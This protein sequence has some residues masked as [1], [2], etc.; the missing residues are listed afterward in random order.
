MP[1]PHTE[2]LPTM[3]RTKA[4]RAVAGS[5]WRFVGGTLT[6]AVPV[7]SMADGAAVLATVLAAAGGGADGHV[8]VEL[9]GGA[10][11]LTLQ[12][13]TVGWV[14][15]TDAD[16]VP[17][18]DKALAAQ[19][20]HGAP[21]VGGR[22]VQVVELAIDAMDIP[23]IRPFWK[24][25]LGYADEAGDGAPDAPLVDPARQGPAIWFQQMDVPRE[26]R[27][28][29]HFDVMVGEDEA[30]ARVQAAIAAGG[31]LL[32]D[33]SARAFWVLADLEGN[34]ICVCTWQDRSD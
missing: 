25:V 8:H 13:A 4:A 26:Q 7:T 28:R 30:D 33:D 18:I 27:N 9:A 19:G 24:A 20:F 23:A 10:V 14:T 22:A 17:V 3:S 32:S 5:G 6:T 21:Q 2:T 11:T 15:Q 29:I 12:T 16:L 34:E 31:R 1:E